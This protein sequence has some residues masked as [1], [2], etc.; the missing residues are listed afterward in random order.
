MINIQMSWIFVSDTGNIFEI[1]DRIGIHF[2]NTIFLL[3]KLIAKQLEI[4]QK[5]WYVSIIKNE[6]IIKKHRMMEHIF[7]F[8]KI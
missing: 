7:I 3:T 2:L 5:K 8:S 4:S 1:Y 6:E